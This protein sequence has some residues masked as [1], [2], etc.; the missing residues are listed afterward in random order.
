[1]SLW[2]F[3]RQGLTLHLRI[4]YNWRCRPCWP[5]ICGSNSTS[6]LS[7]QSAGIIAWTTCLASKPKLRILQKGIALEIGLKVCEKCYLSQYYSCWIKYF[8]R[9]YQLDTKVKYIKDNL[10]RIIHFLDFW[11]GFI[12]INGITY[13]VLCL[14][15][16]WLFTFSIILFYYVQMCMSSLVNLRYRP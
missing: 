4:A 9:I 3:L 12:W 7:L 5:W 11:N 10:L 6:L 13:L 1:M 15:Q 2:F 14:C 16:L 8:K